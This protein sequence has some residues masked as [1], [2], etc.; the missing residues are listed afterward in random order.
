MRRHPGFEEPHVFKP[1]VQSF[2]WLPLVGFCFVTRQGEARSVPRLSCHAPEADPLA[3]EDSLRHLSCG[4]EL[5]A[6][7]CPKTQHTLTCPLFPCPFAEKPVGAVVALFWP[8]G[9][10]LVVNSH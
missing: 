4:L 2:P 7:T 1:R 10:K 8:N 3:S 6:M 5:K 9:M